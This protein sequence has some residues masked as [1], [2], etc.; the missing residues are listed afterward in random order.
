MV[1]FADPVAVRYV[2]P[3]KWFRY[4]KR[5]LEGNLHLTRGEV[6]IPVKLLRAVSAG[7]LRVIEGES[8][9]DCW[10]KVEI[11]EGKRNGRTLDESDPTR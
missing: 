3:Q 6:G 8:R 7:A 1:V 10:E 4:L 2:R 5:D 9:D 11:W